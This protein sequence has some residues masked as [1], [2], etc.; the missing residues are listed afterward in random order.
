MVPRFISIRRFS[1]CCV[2]AIFCFTFAAHAADQSRQRLTAD[3]NWRFNKG[4]SPGAEKTDF[5]DSGWGSLN[6]PHDWRIEGPYSDTEPTGGGGGY[7]PT[8]VGW[9][10][11]AFVAPESWRGRNVFVEFDGVHMNSD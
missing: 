5:N 3:F 10:R 11:R 1:T 7:L 2:A 6:L 4:D 9:Y 8:G